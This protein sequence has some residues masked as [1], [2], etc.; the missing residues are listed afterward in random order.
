MRH[1]MPLRAASTDPYDD[2]PIPIEGTIEA[3]PARAEGAV[4][5]RKPKPRI[6]AFEQKLIS[7][8]HEDTWNRTPNVTGTGAIHVKSFH[9]KMTEE[10]L[11]HIDEMIN[12]WLDE[13]PQYEVKFVTQA[14]GEWRGKV[15][16][17]NLIV[18][19]WV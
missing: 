7:G 9:C 17:P 19:V 1:A 4:A 18:Q 11:H 12:E 2:T 16:E 15:K 14:I 10:G 5:T 3:S 13:H 6:E 8:R